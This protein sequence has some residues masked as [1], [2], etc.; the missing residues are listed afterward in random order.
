[1]PPDRLVRS[2]TFRDL[3]LASGTLQVLLAYRQGLGRGRGGM[4]QL[5]LRD[6][7][8]AHRRH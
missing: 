2:A 3:P 6:D 1:M 7:L 5:D 4:R 8:P